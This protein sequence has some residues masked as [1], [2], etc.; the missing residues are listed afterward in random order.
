[1]SL[2]EAESN[3][4]ILYK[5]IEEFISK[6]FT[7]VP[8]PVHTHR[9][10]APAPAQS[11]PL[12]NSNPL[13]DPVPVIVS[14]ESLATSKSP[15]LPTSTPTPRPDAQIRVEHQEPDD[16]DA[17]VEVTSPNPA[18]AEKSPSPSIPI[19]P[20]EHIA[21]A[22]AL[23]A[24]MLEHGRLKRNDPKKKLRRPE[25][26]PV[27]QPRS[28]KQ[29][30]VNTNMTDFEMEGVPPPKIKRPPIPKPAMSDGE[31]QANSAIGK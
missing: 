17:K 4:R 24:L 21:L 20:L 10:E 5:K 14:T 28:R 23:E 22:S 11:R 15:Y 9:R 19:K 16:V 2:N 7:P 27:L 12:S 25:P 26:I 29:N 30:L 1:M 6:S 31:D 3:L 13:E 18:L 8:V